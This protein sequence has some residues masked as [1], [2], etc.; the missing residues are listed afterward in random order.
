MLQAHI[1]VPARYKCPLASYTLSHKTT[2]CSLTYA[3]TYIQTYVQSY[4][5]CWVEHTIPLPSTPQT[6]TA[7]PQLPLADAQPN[8]VLHSVPPCLRAILIFS[9]NCPHPGLG[10]QADQ[11]AATSA[12]HSALP[13]PLARCP[14][15][16]THPLRRPL[17]T[18]APT[19]PQQHIHTCLHTRSSCAIPR[20]VVETLLYVR[21]ILLLSPWHVQGVCMQVVPEASSNQRGQQHRRGWGAGLWARVSEVCSDHR[22]R[23][24]RRARCGGQA[25]GAGSRRAPPSARTVFCHHSRPQRNL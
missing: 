22:Q 3:H 18:P 8:T 6:P 5:P 23:C 9:T 11:L 19:L 21:A 17:T 1:H 24:T 12:H 15:P 20:T 4:T 13:A 10:G 7:A 2:C 16:R 14:L 25:S